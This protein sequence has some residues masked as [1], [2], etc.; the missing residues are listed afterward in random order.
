MSKV[1]E[2]TPQPQSRTVN[3]GLR[4][5]KKKP[6]H[7]WARRTPTYVCCASG[8]LIL[9]NC[10]DDWS[11]RNSRRIVVDFCTVLPEPLLTP[12]ILCSCPTRTK[13]AIPVTKPSNTG[14]DRNC[15]VR[16]GRGPV[17]Y[18]G[19]LSPGDP[20]S[21]LLDHRGQPR[22]RIRRGYVHRRRALAGSRLG[23]PRF[24]ADGALLG[25]GCGVEG[26]RVRGD[27][28]VHLRLFRTPGRGRWPDHAEHLFRLVDGPAAVAQVRRRSR[29]PRGRA[30]LREVWPLG[31]HLCHPTP[32]GRLLWHLDGH[33]RGPQG[34]GD[35]V[36]RGRADL[37]G[38]RAAAGH[39]GRGPGWGLLR[40][41]GQ[42][43]CD[44]RRVR[45][46]H[47]HPRGRRCDRAL[48]P[49]RARCG[50]RSSPTCSTCPSPWSSVAPARPLATRSWRAC[51]C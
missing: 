35:R 9:K 16:P 49:R 28:A 25:H 48:P 36:L 30:V 22:R 39:A 3:P 44:V 24:G 23:A 40:Y 4:Y 41:W 31:L 5:G 20:L 50:D 32:G 27:G 17:G 7:S 26:H 47:G 33:A 21:L 12:K 14:L 1:I 42:D 37:G 43:L 15:V 29:V 18:V 10:L 11:P 34:S 38:R 13:T 46:G 6:I 51:A 2:P 45:G 19:V 8:S